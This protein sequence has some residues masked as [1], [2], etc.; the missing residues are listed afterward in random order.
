MMGLTPCLAQAFWSSTA[1]FIT[2]WS[3]SPSAGCS[4][5]AARAARCSI[6]HAPS[7][8]EYSEWTCRWAQACDLTA[9][10]DGRSQPG[11]RSALASLFARH[12]QA[13]DERHAVL[14][15]RRHGGARRRGRRALRHARAKALHGGGQRFDHLAV[16]RRCPHR[17][18]R[19]GKLPPD[20]DRFGGGGQGG[21]LGPP[22]RGRLGGRR[23]LRGGGHGG[24]LGP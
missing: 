1:P 21:L 5:C 24:L 11:G 13:P 3:V 20:G 8:S 22:P 9:T 19:R 2:P 23:G 16:S 18:C 4:N 7:S 12:P 15:P 14:V 10:L 6:L 17:R